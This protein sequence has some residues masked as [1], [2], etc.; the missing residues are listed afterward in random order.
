[1]EAGRCG[2]EGGSG[3]SMTTIRLS[4]LPKS[5]QDHIRRVLS[6]GGARGQV[7]G[8]DAQEATCT[9]LS[10][11]C[12]PKRPKRDGPNRT[13]Q[14]YNVQ[15]LSVKGMYEAITFRLPGGSRYTP[16]WVEFLEN[17]TLRVH[18]VKGSYRFPSEGRAWTAFREARAAF[19]HV[20]FVWAKRT[21]DGR[22][23]FK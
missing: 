18:E 10:R 16:D 21:K 2:E 17:G 22:W 5:V 19:P 15:C 23:E 8:Q 1:M 9:F 14:D 3:Q 4:D 13:E 7:V 11:H 20:D 12:R 6:I